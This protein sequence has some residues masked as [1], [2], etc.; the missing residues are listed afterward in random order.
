MLL[1]L[2]VKNFALIDELNIT[3]NKGLNILTGE[4]GAGKSIIIDAVNMAIG[5]RADR[6]FI[7]S[8]A[9]K[10][11]VQAMFS[12]KDSNNLDTVLEQYGIEID[13]DNILI[14]TREIYSNGRSICRIN[15]IIVT[16]TILKIITQRLIDIH[17]QHEHQSL[18]NSNYHINMLDSYGGKEVLDLVASVSK[19]YN[20]LQ[21]LQK[22]LSSICF[23]E[24]ERERKIDLIKFQIDEIDLAN[25]IP[26]EEEELKKQKNI[27][28]N[29]EKIYQTLSNTYEILYG[30]NLDIS[31]LDKLSNVVHAINGISSLDEKFSDFNNILEEVQYKLEDVTRDIR[32]YKDQIDF[33]PRIL[34][35]ME[36]RLDLINIL[37]RK[38]GNSVKE[39]LQYKEKIESELWEFE[40]SEEEIKRLKKEIDFKYKELEHVSLELS[41]LRKIIAA[42]FEKKITNILLTLNMGKIQFKVSFN[43]EDSRYSDIKFTSRG[44]DQIE[45]TISTN[46]GEPLKPLSKIASGGEMSRIM[47]A[48]KTILADVDNIPAL[49]FDEIDTGISG[50]TAQI[51]GERL[52]DIS[53]HHQIICITHLPQIAA[54]ADQHY[55][56]E[57]IEKGNNVKTTVEKLNKSRQI[58]EIG[59][60]LGGELTDIT[61]KHSEEMINQAH[62]RKY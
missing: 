7:R 57:K 29:S 52:Y 53:N 61:I 25:L 49:I 23:D 28:S 50:R 48:F 54:M 46:L 9:D 10:C 22:K 36:I 62:L 44:I 35:N 18:L 32:D 11:M 3:F 15:G 39:I 38:Y 37:K 42:D 1:E 8:G 6:N 31:I 41:A 56:I 51:I 12:L 60:L 34:E 13:S 4:T 33:D 43:N 2:E 27:L 26:N 21:I 19:Q 59:R 58:K 20:E 14:I 40:N 55:L 30:D 5:Q 47:L 16:Q 17:G 45:F 24:M